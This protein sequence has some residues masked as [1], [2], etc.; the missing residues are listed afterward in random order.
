MIA[1]TYQPN[2]VSV[3]MSQH[4]NVD[5]SAETPS[6][7]GVV[8]AQVSDDGGT[9]VVRFV[10]TQPDAVDLSVDVKSD[11]TLGAGSLWVLHSAKLT[12]ANT[13]SQPTF[14]SPSMT[15]V[16]DI[17][18]GVTVPGYSFAIIELRAN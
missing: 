17:G 8:S 14:V 4:S 1:N 13:P 7:K 2:A 6:P 11:K 10:N 9:V 3:T 15:K 5:T 12:D 16:K 18:A